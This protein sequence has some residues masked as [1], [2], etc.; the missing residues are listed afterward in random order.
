MQLIV[1]FV[2]SCNSD[3]HL[4]SLY[5][6]QALIKYNGLS[7]QLARLSPPLLEHQS[8]DQVLLK[9]A[10][11][12]T[13]SEK[14]LGFELNISSS[15]MVNRVP[16]Y[17]N[18]TRVDRKIDVLQL[19]KR[20]LGR[21]A[22]NRVLLTAVSRCDGQNLVKVVT[23]EIL[24][25]SGVSICEDNDDESS[26]VRP[27][28]SDQL[29]LRQQIGN[30]RVVSSLQADQFTY[31]IRTSEVITTLNTANGV[32]KCENRSLKSENDGLEHEN[33]DLKSENRDLKNENADLKSENEYLKNEN[34]DL[35][36]KNED[37]KSETEDLKSENKDVRSQNDELKNENDVLKNEN[38]VLIT[39]NTYLTQQFV[40]S[41]GD[42]HFPDLPVR[43]VWDADVEES[44]LPTVPDQE[45]T[46]GQ[47][48][49]PDDSLSLSTDANLAVN[50]TDQPL[51]DS[52]SQRS[53][54]VICDVESHVSSASHLAEETTSFMVSESTEVKENNSLITPNMIEA[55]HTLIDPA[56]LSIHALD[57]SSSPKTSSQIQ[58]VH[59][60]LEDW[61]EDDI[62]KYLLHVGTKRPFELI[63]EET[64][65]EW[66]K[67]PKQSEM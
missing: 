46:P 20:Q 42:S 47:W 58:A 38:K 26:T 44:V 36:N 40:V 1:I 2:L 9:V 61:A 63:D 14:E 57:S 13:C 16:V 39:E 29:C 5:L 35:K 45:E 15:D 17:E 49:L 27:Q 48:N 55:E 11:E 43:M 54:R 62:E 21:D 8:S 19:W 12:S 66:V 18:S 24:V 53:F 23:D 65:M 25:E 31:V 28:S 3:I 10:R 4:L 7:Q 34:Q 67:S 33:D 22:N 32:L 60:H 64:Q 41:R 6:Y 37:L 52:P 51:C 50:W 30:S 56:Q 59:V